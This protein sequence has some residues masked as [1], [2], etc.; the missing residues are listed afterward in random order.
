M[1]RSAASPRIIHPQMSGVLSL[2]NSVFSDAAPQCCL[3][4]SDPVL[5][6]SV[7]GTVELPGHDLRVM[8]PF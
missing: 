1:H 5:K 4:N 3:F 6:A 2:R 7:S 8:V